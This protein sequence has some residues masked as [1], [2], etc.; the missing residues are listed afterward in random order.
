M[1]HEGRDFGQIIQQALAIDRRLAKP[2]AQRIMMGAE[3]IELHFQA[4]EMRQIAHPD[5]AAANLVFIGRADPAPGGADL[6]GARSGF[7]QQIEIAVNRQ[8]QRAIIGN[9]EIGAG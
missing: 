4:A 8:D 7:A 5:R 2:G 9:C 6:A 3:P 1:Q